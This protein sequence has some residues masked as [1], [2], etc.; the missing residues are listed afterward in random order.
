VVDRGAPSTREIIDT[1]ELLW[2]SE[3]ADPT[4]FRLFQ[5]DDQGVGRDLL[6]LDERVFTRLPYRDWIERPLEGG[7][8]IHWQWLD[9][10]QRSLHDVIQFAAPALA[11]SV[12]SSD[13]LLVSFALALADPSPTSSPPSARDLHGAWREHVIFDAVSGALTLTRASGLWTQGTVEIAYHHADIEGHQVDGV[14]EWSGELAPVDLATL[15][16]SRLA[17][18]AATALPERTRY[19]LEKRELL[20]DLAGT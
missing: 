5:G 9:D 15:D 11:L 8:A 6:V 18:P 16:P 12:T 20:R 4:R 2:A 17:P 10:A 19:E 13:E 3:S 7:D 1:L 14:L